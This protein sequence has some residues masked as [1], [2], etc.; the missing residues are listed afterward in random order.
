MAKQIETIIIF[1]IQAYEEIDV[2]AG[3]LKDTVTIE[4]IAETVDGAIDKA[5]KIIKKKFYRVTSIIEKE[6][7]P[8]P[9]YIMGS[10]G[11]GNINAN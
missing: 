3:T 11:R 4:V 7:P 8:E 9:I 2:T 10:G 5:K 1:I 6:L